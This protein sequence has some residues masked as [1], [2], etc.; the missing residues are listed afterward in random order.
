MEDSMTTDTMMET[1]ETERRKAKSFTRYIPP[2]ARIFMGLIFFVSGIFGLLTLL[3]IV[4]QPSMPM[5]AG[6]AAFAGA[7]AKTGYVMP[8]TS[9]TE[10]IGGALLLLSRFVPLALALLAPLIVNIVAFHAFLAPSG[11]GPA[12]V[13]AALEVY[14]AWAYRKA[15]RPMLA[16]RAAPDAT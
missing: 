1:G 15:Y 5:P 11:T 3:G 7:L 6:A 14:L 4:P 10:V 12:V 8:L 13:V 2:V 16:L 9:G